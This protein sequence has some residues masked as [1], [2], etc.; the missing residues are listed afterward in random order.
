[1]SRILKWNVKGTLPLISLGLKVFCCALFILFAGAVVTLL[2]AGL[3]AVSF[4]TYWK[5][6]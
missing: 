2:I 4:N 6:E 1:M 5:D 3:F